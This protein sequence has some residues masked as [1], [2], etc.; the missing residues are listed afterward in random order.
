MTEKINGYKEIS[1]IVLTYNP[2]WDKMYITLQSILKQKDINL[3][4]IIAD[5]GSPNFSEFENALISYFYQNEFVKYKIIHQDSNVGTVC[6]LLAAVQKTTF[7][8]IKVIS[9][10]DA[11]FSCSILCDWLDYVIANDLELSAGLAVWYEN[12]SSEIKIL[13]NYPKMP[14]NSHV[15]LPNHNY[16]ECVFN[17]LRYENQVH[18]ASIIVNR[19]ILIKYMEMLKNNGIILIEDLFVNIAILDKCK[20]GFYPRY[21]VWYEFNTGVTSSVSPNR[22]FYKKVLDDDLRKHKSLIL[23]NIENINDF[24]IND[25]MAFVNIKCTKTLGAKLKSLFYYVFFPQYMI[26]MLKY[27]FY[28]R[29]STK[30]TDKTFIES[31]INK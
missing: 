9:P 19:E 5:D 31:C 12:K 8:Y 4:I 30:V 22:F 6:N 27:K 10:G 28:K 15:L 21:T 14:K 24:R 3:E 20:V 11:L 18:G 26:W 25:I 29:K 23:K 13:D 2:K 16:Y 17:M 1:V 7:K